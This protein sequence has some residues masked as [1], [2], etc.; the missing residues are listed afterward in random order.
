MQPHAAWC[1]VRG[2]IRK[3]NGFHI[4]EQ[5]IKNTN[6]DMFAHL[7]LCVHIKCKK[8]IEGSFKKWLLSIKVHS[9]C[10]SCNYNNNKSL[11]VLTVI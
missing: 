11:T 1:S 3:I 8:N 4:L 7:G 2:C 10:S 5:Y 9:L 6:G